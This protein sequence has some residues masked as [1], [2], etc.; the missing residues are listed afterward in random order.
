MTYPN[1]N[2]VDNVD[3]VQGV[4]DTWDVIAKSLTKPELLTSAAEITGMLTKLSGDALMAIETKY[5]EQHSKH[6]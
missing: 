5:N 6:D 4:V 1:P 2:F 3:Y